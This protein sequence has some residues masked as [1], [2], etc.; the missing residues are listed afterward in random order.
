MK[1]LL[2]NDDGYFA[3]GLACL[4][5]KLA[6]LGDVVVVAPERDRSGVS[7]SLTL[8]RPLIV[9]RAANGF[10][11]VNGTPSDCVHLAVTSFLDFKPDLVV[12]GINHGANMGEDTLYSG[13]VAAAMEA[14]LLGIPAL[15]VSLAGRI[16]NHFDTAA[17]VAADLAERFASQPPASPIL[18]NLN[19]PDMPHSALKGIKVTRLGRRHQVEP[20]VKSLNPRGETIYWVGAVG[21]AQ[22]AREDTDFYAVTAGYASLTPLMVDLTAHSLLST[23]ETWLHR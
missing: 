15:A 3:P 5:E 2:C 8:D 13:T 14:Y 12:S 1:F 4:A 23:V 10:Y 21:Q 9:R 7:N 19:V 6:S 16:D 17:A 22:D 11:Y 20:A 18:L